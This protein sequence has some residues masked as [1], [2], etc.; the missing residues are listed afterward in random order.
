[1]AR[2]F[3]EL[4]HTPIESVEISHQRH[5][6]PALGRWS[7]LGHGL[8]VD[9]SRELL[10]AGSKLASLEFGRTA[11]DGAQLSVLL[12]P[13]AKVED[14]IFCAISTEFTVD[15]PDSGHSAADAITALTDRWEAFL[16][17]DAQIAASI[18]SLAS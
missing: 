4:P 5:L 11:D 14:G 10:L 15:E 6:R 3:A 7:P 9:D 16:A 12:E 17:L 1:V 13:S 2:L 18:L 8:I